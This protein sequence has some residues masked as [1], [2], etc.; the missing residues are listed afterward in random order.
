M[1]HA[2]GRPAEEDTLREFAEAGGSPP[3]RDTTPAV[4]RRGEAGGWRRAFEGA[5]VERVR[6]AFRDGR[7]SYL[8][9]RDTRYRAREAVDGT[10]S[11]AARRMRGGAETPARISGPFVNGPVWT[12][13][14]PVYFWLGGI[15]TG[16]SFVAV[17]ADAAGDT[18]TARIARRVTLAA[19]LPGSPLLILDLGRPLRFLHMLRIFKPRSP[20]SM[21]SW[22]LTAFTNTAMGAVGADLL[23][24][25]RLARGL[26]GA[27]AGLGLYLGSYTGVLLAAT[28]IPV[29]ARS[30]LLL[31]P[32][33]VST[34][35]AGGAAANRLLLSALGR[36][37]DHPASRALRAIETGAMVADLA[38]SQ[39]NGR[40][41]GRVGHALHHGRPGR[42][43]RLAETGIVAG[44]ATRL[45]RRRVGATAD[46]AA[47]S[48]FLAAG[49]A[50]RF[51]WVEAGRASA[52][53][54]EAVA[55]NAR[56][57]GR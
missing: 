13:E 6:G 26:G 27:T 25:P 54:D 23:G 45:A 10:V 15:A 51:A 43:H 31:A 35:V 3:G 40:R 32:I 47:S 14:I 28:A 20:M 36:G 55:I 19:V 37:A 53:D 7:W 56:R 39:V 49:L 24:R 5:T 18:R 46:H 11:E 2:H 34:G 1:T 33:F 50:F 42:L 8:Y 30:R 12:W 38:L 52:A 41:L 29:W 16:S 17:A 4:G 44:L 48:L 57:A 21:G 22:C 9:G